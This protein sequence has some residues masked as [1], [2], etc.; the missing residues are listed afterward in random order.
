MPFIGFEFPVYSEPA[1]E[2]K[3]LINYKNRKSDI[4]QRTDLTLKFI[5]SIHTPIKYSIIQ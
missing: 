2:Y 4:T 1:N 3:S 5:L